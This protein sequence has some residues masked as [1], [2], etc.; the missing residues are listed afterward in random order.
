MP[1][2]QP[3]VFLIFLRHDNNMVIFKEFLS[4]VIY[5]KIMMK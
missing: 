3:L 1:H 5:T 2:H 4:F